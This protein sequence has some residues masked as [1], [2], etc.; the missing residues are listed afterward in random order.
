MKHFYTLLAFVISACLT[1][2]A[3]TW[4]Y[5]WPVS[6]TS[7]KPDYANGFYN[8]G[9]G[10]D[11][12]ITS[13]TRTLNGKSWTVNFEKDTKL[14]YTTSSGQAVGASGGFT[15]YFSLVSD[16]FAGK[17]KSVSLKTRSKV[18]GAVVTVSVNG[19][20]YSCDGSQSASYYTVETTPLDLKFVPGDDGEQEGSIVVYFTIPEAQNNS[21]V[22]ELTVEYEAA[23]ATVASPVITPEAGS[24]DEAFEVSVSAAD[25]AQIF[26][27]TDGS[28]P[29][30]AGVAYDG[31][32]TVA[33]T[34]TVKAVA[35]VGEDW[36]AIVE[37]KYIIRTSPE[38]SF[39]KESFTIE[40]LEED[41]AM[42][43]NP[44]NVSPLKFSSSKP[45]VAYA[46]EHGK[47]Y[48]YSVGTC[49]ISATFAGDDNY[50]PQT[51]SVP[52]EVI[53]KEPLAGLTVTPAS[54]DYKDVVNVEVTCT[55]PRAV[56][57][58]Y[59]IGDKPAVLDD[60][61]ILDEY[62]IWP[63]TE[64]TLEVDHSCVITF[65]AMGNNVWSEPVTVTYNVELPLKA[66]F[67]AGRSYKK[68]YSN[69]FD[70]STEAAEWDFSS[71]S[72]WQLTPDAGGYQAPAFSS[73]DSNSV[74]SLM[75]AYANTGETAVATSPVIDVPENGIVRFYAIFNPVWIYY[76]N[77]MLYVCEDAD[78]AV[79]VKIWDAF[80]S[81]QEA[82]TDDIKWTQY[83]VALDEYA[84]KKVY[85][86]FA[87][88][89]TDGDNVVIDGFEVVAPDGDGST[90]NVAAGDPVTFT[91]KSTGE[92]ESY[93]WQFP[94]AVTETS[95]E[96]NPTVVYSA[97]GTYDV[98]LTVIRGEES[99]TYIR[100]AYVNV[101]AVAPTAA[102]AIPEGVY[103]SPEAGIV[104]PLNTELTF[105]D[106]SAGYPTSWSWTLPGTDLGSAT[107]Q[108]V[109]VKY[110]TEGMYDVDLE[111]GNDVGKSATYLHGVK[112]GGESLVWNIAPSE[113]ENLGRM[114]LGWY[115]NYG[116]TNWLGMTAF[117]EA[118]EA[119][120]VPAEISSV[121]IYF[122][123]TTAV[124]A[125]AAITVSVTEADEN[126]MPGNVL[127]TSSM[128]VSQL[129]DASETYNDP[130]TFELD[131]TVEVSGRF[132][133]TVSG[134]PNDAN[135]DGEDD[136]AMYVLYRGGDKLNTAYHLLEETDASYQPTGE[137]K[138][139]AQTD[140]PCS[141]AIAPKIKFIDGGDSI[142]A[143][144]ADNSDAPAEY[145]NLQGVRVDS[146]NLAPGIYI[147]RRGNVASKQYVR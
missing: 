108:S 59:Y 118:F 117:A 31:P 109:T 100:K 50:L 81:S 134:F 144:E 30:T 44:H 2:S 114:S 20:P 90:I 4:T 133:V 135:N 119:P 32:F 101:H 48:T 10:F 132:F 57:I 67:D 3:D 111:V 27:T 141:F 70:S 123:S 40:L 28:D 66:N 113:N 121:N 80:L 92:P 116:G 55:D 122:A 106:A 95:A 126:G 124:T 34:C 120:L 87:Y 73:I 14:S 76:G 146:R 91:D 83:S 21:Y 137:Y 52:V 86:A 8:F 18:E 112:A 93:S 63:S 5:D 103:R 35:K 75:H 26:Y 99:D 68:I 138:W 104:V 42:V 6:S 147:V 11:G 43:N 89:L 53:A 49:T 64:M 131:K 16:A 69:G 139:Y 25:G 65:Q 19:K 145:Y 15:T 74:Y 39:A 33:E 105:A 36:S 22:K 96:Q 143:V 79:P 97:P 54:G 102:I 60:L 82:A 129:V 128:P 41:F 142:D 51:I 94:G 130:T 72:N 58:W 85:F 78:G 45:A 110:V 88:E 46:D 77:L 61:G 47:I 115:G 37:S 98:T 29:R 9:S 71:G 23:E 13:K 56:T 127:A 107:D 24:Y 38:L 140:D 84:G 125:D 1:V 62:E 7:D 136:I 17:I 12:E